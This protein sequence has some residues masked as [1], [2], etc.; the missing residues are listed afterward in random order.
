MFKR[1]DHRQSTPRNVADQT[2]TGARVDELVKL[3]DKMLAAED[4][5][6]ARIAYESALRLKGRSAGTWHRRGQV[7]IREGSIKEAIA[8]FVRSIEIDSKKADVW[9]SLGKAILEFEEKRVDPSLIQENPNAIISE[10]RD[11]FERA[12]KLDAGSSEARWGV[13]ACKSKITSEAYELAR[14]P[15]FSFHPG[16][17]LDDV[18]QKV[19]S[20]YL[21]PS[22]YRFKDSPP[23]SND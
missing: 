4:F 16:G 6:G 2:E 14:P 7:F 5:E 8:C 9:C 23:T 18:K 12:L 19:V 13:N 10:A 11:C 1:R 17:I 20:P 15:L 3:G 21:K 22:D